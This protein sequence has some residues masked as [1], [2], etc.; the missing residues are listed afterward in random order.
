MV[1]SARASHPP[2]VGSWEPVPSIADIGEHRVA[3][4]RLPL[5][6]SPINRIIHPGTNNVNDFACTRATCFNAAS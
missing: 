1:W 3:P 2:E 4:A 6:A 5:R